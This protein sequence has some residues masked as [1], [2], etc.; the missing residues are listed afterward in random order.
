[1]PKKI[2]YAQ[3]NKRTKNKN[4][5]SGVTGVY[6]DTRNQKWRATITVNYKKI[7]LGYYTEFEK[8]VEA[9]K[10]AE[11]FYNL[12][13]LKEIKFKVPYFVLQCILKINVQE[14]QD[15][16]EKAIQGL[17]KALLTHK[18][19]GVSFF[20]YACDVIQNYINSD[21]ISEINTNIEIDDVMLDWM[22]GMSLSDIANKYNYSKSTTD[23]MIRAKKEKIICILLDK[24]N[25]L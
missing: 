2:V 9:R 23:R 12:S 6:F 3:K 11:K 19:N 1:M 8:A 13:N 20:C 5:S 25:I 21:E 18:N 24:D 15:L 14:N 22:N 10:N 7:R 16:Y 17:F 4:N